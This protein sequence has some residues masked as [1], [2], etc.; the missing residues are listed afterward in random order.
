MAGKIHNHGCVME[1]ELPEPDVAALLSLLGAAVDDAVLR[2]LDGTG[3]RRAHGYLVQR[4][5][6]RPSTATEL[7]VELGVSQQAVSKA[8]K[9]LLD[10]GHVEHAD[11]PDDRRRRPVR[12]TAR[13]RKAVATARAARAELDA[14]LRDAWGPDR[15][16]A[17]AAGLREAL[18]AL[19]L[20]DDVRRRAVPPPGGALPG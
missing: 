1:E 15:F 11:D 14:R 9:E 13:G 7:A 17:T 12:L 4:L 8:I 3:L 10:L 18:D 16:A 5:L 19:G 6:V 2:A 20:G